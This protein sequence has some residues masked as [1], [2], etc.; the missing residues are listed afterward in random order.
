MRALLRILVLGL[1][2]GLALP[3]LAGP[4]IT[5]TNRDH[6]TETIVDTPFC[7]PGAT[8]EITLDYKLIEHVTA[9]DDGRVHANFTQTGTFDAQPLDTTGQS[10]SGHFAIWG[11]FNDNGKA[12]NGTFTFNVNGSFADETKLSVHLVDHFNVTPNGAEFFFTRC[13]D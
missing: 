4:P 10:A 9:F 1:V 6:I 12:V 11:G 8:H 3:A 2:L 5:E 13:K 7:E